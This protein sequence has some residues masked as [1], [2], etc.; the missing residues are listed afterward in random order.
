MAAQA[1]RIVQQVLL[2]PFFLKAWGIEIYTD[3]LLINA[4][5]TFLTIFDGGMQPYFSG[6]LQEHLVRGDVA[7]YRRAGRIASFNYLAV[8][9]LAI[10]VIATASLTVDWLSLLGVS[11]LPTIAAYWT[12]ALLAANSLIALPFGVANA[13][14]RAHGEYDRSV[15]MGTGYL[16]IQIVFPLI[17]LLIG[18]PIVMLAAI[19]VAGTIL[20]WAII[21]IDQKMRYGALPWGP[22]IPTME[23]QR[24]TAAKCLYFL[25][26]PI[27]T[28]LIF[29]GPLLVLGHMGSAID[30]VTFSAARTLVGVSRQI[31]V[32]SAYPFGFELSV[33]LIRDELAALRR[34][35]ENTLSIVGIIGGLLA[36]VTVV[37][38]APV[39]ALWLRGRIEIPQSLVIAMAIP[40]VIA[41]A[42]QIYP[43][44]LSFANR[45]RLIANT[46][47]IQATVALALA[48]MLAPRFGALGVAVGLGIGEVIAVVLY[49]PNR[50]QRTVGIASGS[51][52]AAATVRAMLAAVLGY[53]VGRLTALII[54]PT[55]YGRLVVFGAIWTVIAGATAVFLLLNAEQRAVISRKL[56]ALRAGYRMPAYSRK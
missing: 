51:L 9:L 46:V 19:T 24:K 18:Q 27:T 12:L 33:L 20:S 3:W 43:L 37:A 42:A 6:L 44:V 15:L 8:I 17:F 21:G 16:A 28:S 53:G 54:M 50:T 26:Q 36:G 49:L 29:Q 30:V 38:A 31:T 56:T 13:V 45:P 4:G 11:R 32:Q 14:Y 23:E 47:A 10:A 5:V 22:A 52:Q 35:L 39:T 41:A 25:S 2:V 40:I 48:A 7:Q 1:L 55:D 34:L